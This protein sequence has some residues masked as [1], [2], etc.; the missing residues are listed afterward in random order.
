MSTSILLISTD[1]ADDLRWSLPAALAQPDAEVV[2]V[3][4]A[5]SDATGELAARHGARHLRL[6]TRVSWCEANEAAIQATDGD[7]V[8]LLN[9]D[10]FLAPDF[11]ERARARL[12]E[13][14]IGAVA[15]KLIR[16][17]G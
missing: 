4:N 6:D 15:P 1:R 3:D 14:G 7:S 9:A 5:S 8:L 12:A 17:E 11:L 2:V 16:T 10:C 13:P